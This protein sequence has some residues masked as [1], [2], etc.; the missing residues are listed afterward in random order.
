MEQE[1]SEFWYLKALQY[2]EPA[3]NL[4]AK[5][6]GKETETL[7]KLISTD[8]RTINSEHEQVANVC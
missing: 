4:A 3:S 1:Q 2:T 8:Q 5:K 6:T 7:C